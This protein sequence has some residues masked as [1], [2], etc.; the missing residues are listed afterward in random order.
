MSARKSLDN[1]THHLGKCLFC[2]EHCKLEIWLFHLGMLQA[3]RKIK[4]ING[5]LWANGTVS[6][7]YFGDNPINALNKSCP[8]HQLTSA[9]L[10]MVW[11]CNCLENIHADDDLYRLLAGFSH[12]HIQEVGV[13]WFS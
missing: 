3:K 10:L 12:R 8:V 4:P 7:R 2:T 13:R 1:N 11:G 6:A 5:T 9:L